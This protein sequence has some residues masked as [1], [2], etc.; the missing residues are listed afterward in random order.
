[1]R[2][3][4]RSSPPRAGGSSPHRTR[5][6]AESRETSTTARNN[7]SSRLTRRRRPRR[8]KSLAAGEGRLLVS[9]RDDGVGGADRQRGTGLVGL[10]D[11]VE[12]LGGSIRVSSPPGGGTKLIATLPLELESTED[13]D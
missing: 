7:G 4:G 11:R 5:L 6:A 8:P 12:A 3:T 10:T 9:I 2:T 13:V 1:M